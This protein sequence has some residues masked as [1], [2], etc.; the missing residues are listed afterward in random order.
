M[1]FVF[2][3]KDFANPFKFTVHHAILVL[4]V[5]FTIGNITK[6]ECFIAKHHFYRVNKNKERRTICSMIWGLIERVYAL[7]IK[8]SSD[9][10]IEQNWNRALM[11]CYNLFLS[12]KCEMFNLSIWNSS[13]FWQ[14]KYLNDHN[15]KYKKFHLFFNL[16]C[17]YGIIILQFDR[18]QTVS[19]FYIL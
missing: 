13:K 5:D 9:G 19:R 3:A 11:T 14:M 4:L 6:S 1:I 10:W 18:F 16:K 7:E 15:K 12:V 17:L 2:C 8:F